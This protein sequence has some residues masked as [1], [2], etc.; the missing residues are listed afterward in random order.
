MGRVPPLIEQM[1][2]NI[3]KELEIGKVEKSSQRSVKKKKKKKAKSE[4]I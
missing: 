3:W 2:K 4:R 1:D